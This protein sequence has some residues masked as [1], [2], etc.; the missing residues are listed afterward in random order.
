MPD[1]RAIEGFL[2]EEVRLLDDREFEAWSDLFTDDGIYWVPAVPGQK[3]PQDH[4]SLFYDD[5]EM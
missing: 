2:F 5:K 1:Q 4:V 3:N